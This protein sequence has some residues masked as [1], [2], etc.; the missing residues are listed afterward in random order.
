M[1]LSTAIQNF[2]SLPD[3]ANVR[4]AD[5]LVLFAMS[6]SSIRRRIKAGTFPEANPKDEKS[7]TRIA[8]YNVGKV[9]QA[10]TSSR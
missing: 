8:A 10:L 6:E 2:D 1:A 4:M 5:L 9:R 3:S 7:T